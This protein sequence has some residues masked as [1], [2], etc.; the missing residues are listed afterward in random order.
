MQG[1]KK[2]QKN[3]VGELKVEYGRVLGEMP[4]SA[5]VGVDTK[6]TTPPS[7]AVAATPSTCSTEEGNQSCTPPP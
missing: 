6:L 4:P 1:L 7:V 2:K 5:G 3:D